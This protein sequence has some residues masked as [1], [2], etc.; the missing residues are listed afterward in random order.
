VAIAQSASTRSELAARSGAFLVRHKMFIAVELVLVAATLALVV[1]VKGHLGPLPGD[2]SITLW[3]QHLVRPHQGLTAVLNEVSAIN[4]PKPAAIT[5]AVIVAAFALLRRWLAILVALSMELADVT[6]FIINQIVQ[7]P[8]P[9]GHGVF[10]DRMITGVYSF[11]SGHVEHALAFLGIVV[12][13]TFQVRRSGPWL[14]PLLWVVRI[15]LIAEIVLMSPSRV[16]QGEH[17]PSDGLAG[18][19]WGGFWLL[20]G[21]QVYFW[22]A[23]RWPRLVP[24]NERREVAV[25][26]T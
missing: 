26:A 1:I 9:I 5:V 25:H 20:V 14:T 4:W 10:V 16:L 7:R 13:L 24:A 17:W 22:A 2:V 15:A 19:L 21:I 3:W 18:L 11:P 6:N 23:R 8:R 12:F